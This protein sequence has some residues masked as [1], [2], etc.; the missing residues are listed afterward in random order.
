MQY[1]DVDLTLLHAF[2]AVAETGSITR[3]AHRLNLTQPAVSQ[4]I[5]RLEDRL[6]KSLFAAQKRPKILTDEGELL[7][8][9]ARAILRLHNEAMTRLVQP[10]MSGRVVLGTPDLY[11]CFFLPDILADFGRA[12]PTVQINL[13]CALTVPLLQE[14]EKGNIDIV[15]AT[16]MPSNSPG[17][18]VR[19]ELLHFVTGENSDAHKQ[20]PLP[21]AMLPPGNLYR[22]H[23][24]E[25]LETHGRPWRIACESESIAGLLAAVQA[26]LAVTVLTQP[27]VGPGL[28]VCSGF[29][30]MPSLPSVDLTLYYDT[31]RSDGIARHLAD[32]LMKRLA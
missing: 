16:Q 3:A 1:R 11:A 30:G 7:Y 23:A 22:D 25:A 17:H 24:L 13:Q 27:A 31:E 21:L 4:Q 19:S 6:Q 10:K 18:F 8:G 29:D 28:R 2:A 20:T 15:L 26:G 14:F 12:Y 32:Y 9:Y 5:N